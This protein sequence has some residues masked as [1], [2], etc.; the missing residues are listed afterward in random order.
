MQHL[1]QTSLIYVTQRCIWKSFVRLWQKWKTLAW[2]LFLRVTCGKQSYTDA[3]AAPWKSS[4]EGLK[5][6]IPTDVIIALEI[7]G[8]KESAQDAFQGLQGFPSKSQLPR[9]AEKS[10]PSVFTRY[11]PRPRGENNKIGGW[12]KEAA[13]LWLSVTCPV[14]SSMKCKLSPQFLSALQPGGSGMQRLLSPQLISA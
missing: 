11:N 1:D 8:R 3:T 10:P 5:I 2:S 4:A 6:L 7:T 9:P 12:E 14:G 13:N